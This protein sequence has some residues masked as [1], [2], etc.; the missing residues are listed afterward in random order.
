M[1]DAAE[2]KRL[3][4]ESGMMLLKEK[5]AARTWGN[6]SCRT[7]EKSMVITPSGL[8]YDGMKPDDI[9]SV[10]MQTGEWAGERKPSSEK[11]IHISAYRQFPDA[12]FVIHTHQTYA[13]AIGLSG[14]DTLSLSEEEKDELGGIALAGYGMSTTKKLARY[15]AAAFESGAHTVLMAHHGAVIVG[16]D[17]EETFRRALLL[18]NVCRRACKGQP[19]KQPILDEELAER[20]LN[21]VKKDFKH[22]SHIASPPVLACASHGTAVRAQLDDMAQMIGAKL[23]VAKP[24]ES[25]VADALKKHEAVLVPGVGAICR[26]P[27]Q[28]DISALC[29]LAEKSCICWLHTQAAGAEVRLSSFDIWLM[30]KVYL[31][32]YSKKIAS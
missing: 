3:T 13:S 7:G 8:G 24:E 30:R 28:D 27:T 15:V 6:I 26:A 11:G 31:M 16:K 4:A 18:E 5:L 23:F 12:G 17:R 25:A 21:S 1:M 10:D 20:L 19:G 22:V 9:V 29:L 14:F 2:A 32:K